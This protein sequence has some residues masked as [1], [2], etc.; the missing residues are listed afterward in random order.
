MSRTLVTI[1]LVVAAV[2]IAWF[3][4]SFLLSFLYFVVRIDA[5]VLT[6]RSDLLYVDLQPMIVSM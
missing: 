4:V 1:L 5:P 2:V 3:L 6:G